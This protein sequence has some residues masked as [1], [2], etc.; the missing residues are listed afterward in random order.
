M[1]IAEKIPSKEPDGIAMIVRILIYV[2]NAMGTL[3][4]N[5][6]IHYVRGQKE[7]KSTSHNV[8]HSMKVIMTKA[9]PRLFCLQLHLISC[10][11]KFS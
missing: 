7:F 1:T 2:A 9:L 11:A 10:R 8:S 6:L 3:L 4:G 5:G